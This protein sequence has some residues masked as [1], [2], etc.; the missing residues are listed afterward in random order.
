MIFT[1]DPTA[2]CTNRLNRNT[3]KQKST[4]T[5][6]NTNTI[7]TSRLPH[8][9][10]TICTGTPIYVQF[11][12]VHNMH[13]LCG[14]LLRTSYPRIRNYADKRWRD[15]DRWKFSTFNCRTTAHSYGARYTTT[16]ETTFTISGARDSC[17]VP[18]D[19]FNVKFRLR[20]ASSTIIWLVTHTCYFSTC[21]PR[22]SPQ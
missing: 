7:E 15:W 19:R 16:T 21:E 10:S 3:T 14:T 5:L 1:T 4:L 9:L 12:Y 6:A 11:Y 18:S 13:L 2:H 17:N 20:W 8:S 22:P